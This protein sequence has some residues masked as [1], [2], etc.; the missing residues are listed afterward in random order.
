MKKDYPYQ[1][2]YPVV[3]VELIGPKRKLKVKALIDSGADVSLFRAEVADYLGISLEK[4]KKI[5]LGGIGGKISTY[6]HTLPLRFNNYS[7]NCKI[8]FS[9]EIQTP[10]NLLGRDNFFWPFLITF[11]GKFQKVL[12][13]KH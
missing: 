12:I 13:E 9:R 6:I 8:A 2:N 7:L 3:E 4:G 1:K 5:F 10:V 11:N